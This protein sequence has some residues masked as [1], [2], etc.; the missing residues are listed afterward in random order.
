ML[1]CLILKK[2][3]IRWYFL[4]LLSLASL[5]ILITNH[6]N[7]CSCFWFWGIYDT[8]LHIT[9]KWQN[10]VQHNFDIEQFLCKKNYINWLI[11][12][13]IKALSISGSAK[14]CF[15]INVTNVLNMKNMNL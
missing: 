10:T 11:N 9:R 7:S 12:L 4:L 1:S 14:D 13:D 2:D 8:S 3:C 15:N 5:K 6:N